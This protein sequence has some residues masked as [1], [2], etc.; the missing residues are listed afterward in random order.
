M[1]TMFKLLRSVLETLKKKTPNRCKPGDPIADEDIECP[2]T[3]SNNP[4][5]SLG[6]AQTRVVRTYERPKPLIA[7]R[8]HAARSSGNDTAN[9]DAN[10]NPAAE[11]PAHSPYTPSKS[12]M[13][14]VQDGAHECAA[15]LPTQDFARHVQESLQAKRRFFHLLERHV[16]TE[17]RRC[18]Q[19]WEAWERYRRLR[20]GV[21]IRLEEVWIGCGLLEREPRPEVYTFHEDLWE[22]QGEADDWSIFGDGC[23]CGDE[24]ARGGGPPVLPELPFARE[25]EREDTQFIPIFPASGGAFDTARCGYDV[26]R[27]WVVGEELEELRVK[28]MI[29]PVKEVEMRMKQTMSLRRKRRVHWDERNLGKLLDRGLVPTSWHAQS[30]KRRVADRE[31]PWYGHLCH[32][33]CDRA[34]DSLTKTR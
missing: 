8:L 34:S 29:K 9:A 3:V 22:E 16:C 27:S 7:Q 6:S 33:V 23:G 11:D 18:K 25:R 28:T 30:R 19:L 20:D 4:F 1:M 24:G 13:V 32:D 12:R 31:Q 15:L 26:P 10:A 14:R 2:S 17:K 5:S 21:D